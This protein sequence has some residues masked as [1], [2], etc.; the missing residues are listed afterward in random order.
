MCWSKPEQMLRPIKGRLR[1]LDPG[2]E[3]LLQWMLCEVIRRR[4]QIQHHLQI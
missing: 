4:N 2:T 3:L 1:G